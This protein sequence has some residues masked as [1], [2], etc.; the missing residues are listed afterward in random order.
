MHEKRWRK[1]IEK[2]SFEPP[3]ESYYDDLPIAPGIRFYRAIV[4][5]KVPLKHL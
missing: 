5:S 1:T 3:T 4:E 2:V